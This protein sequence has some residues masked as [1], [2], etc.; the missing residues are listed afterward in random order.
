MEKYWWGCPKSGIYAPNSK[1]VDI[2]NVEF[3]VFL[4]S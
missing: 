1:K 4:M 3:T 2:K